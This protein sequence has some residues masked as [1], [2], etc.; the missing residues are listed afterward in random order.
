MSVLLVGGTGRLG[1]RVARELLSSGIAV[2]AMCR[3]GAAVGMLRRL[4]AELVTADLRDTD[5]VAAACTGITTVVCTATAAQRDAPDAIVAVDGLAIPAL[6]T[7]AHSQGAVRGVYVSMLPASANHPVLL[8]AAKGASEAALKG[9]GLDWSVIAPDMVVDAWVAPML[10]RPWL[11]GAA[12]LVPTPTDTTHAFIAEHDVAL[13]CAAVVRAGRGEGRLVI[14]GP[15]A[16]SWSDVG[17]LAAALDPRLRE[18]R[19]DHHD[20]P[21][22]SAAI[23]AALWDVARAW[24]VA[25]SRDDSAAIMR[26]HGV[27]ATPIDAWM[28]AALGMRRDA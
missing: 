27:T 2:R 5:A 1:A 26:A 3:A 24:D 12:A 15:Q 21:P 4:G 18:A 6:W 17:A 10:L 11:A 28:R 7:T 23:P 22:P 9:S 19:V 14:G 25:A 16:A 8:L 20:G 13:L